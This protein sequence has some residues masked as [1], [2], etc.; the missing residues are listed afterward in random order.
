MTAFIEKNRDNFFVL[1]RLDPFM[2]GHKG[3]VC[4]GCFKNLFNSE[5]MKDIDIFFES[6]E[7]WFSAVQHYDQECGDPALGNGSVFYLY[8]NDNVKAYMHKSTGTRIELCRRIFGT[9]EQ[10]ISQFDFTITKMAYF[11]KTVEEAGGGKHIEYA[12]L[13]HKDFFEHLHNKRL[14]IDDA[15]PFPMSTLERMFRYVRYGYG[16]CRETKIKIA[17]AIRELSP[18][19]IEV[20]DNLY[21]GMD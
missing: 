4:G 5:K 12:L 7:D 21:K 17:K 11:K 16:P 10:I 18:D 20:S 19:Q 3:F 8:E 9:P 15:I 1:N 6:S 13:M 2:A 14:V